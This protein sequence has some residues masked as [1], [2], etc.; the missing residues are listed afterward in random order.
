MPWKDYLQAL[1]RDPLAAPYYVFGGKAALLKRSLARLL[2]SSL[3]DIRKEFATPTGPLREVFDEIAHLPYLGWTSAGEVLYAAVRARK[4][5]VV[6]ETGVAAGLSSACILAGLQRNGMG[7]LYSI[8]LP[9][10]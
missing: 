7:E 1:N 5:S 10:A 4:P 8:D 9:N 6:V 3:P 2:G